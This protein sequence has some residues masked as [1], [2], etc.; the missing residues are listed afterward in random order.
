[1]FKKYTNKLSLEEIMERQSP[2]ECDASRHQSTSKPMLMVSQD[3]IANQENS[4]EL[5]NTVQRLSS[6]SINQQ[7]GKSMIKSRVEIRE[8]TMDRNHLEFPQRES[9]P[10]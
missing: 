5:C 1:M 2:L 4:K 3:K 9:L 8:A 10:A 7:P 6:I